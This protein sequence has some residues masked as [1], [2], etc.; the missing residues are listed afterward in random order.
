MDT[1][2]GAPQTP[3][4][5]ATTGAVVPLP[6]GLLL[7]QAV[8]ADLQQIG[9]LLA[10]RGEPDDALDHRLVVE[11]PRAGWESCAVVVDGDR[12]V[13]TATLLDERLSLGG[14]E[15]PAGQVELVATARDHEGRSLSGP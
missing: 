12:V 4:V 1:A 9:D 5:P 2:R 11:D 8:P 7:R 15:L 3:T 10:T 13:S 6:D 14:V